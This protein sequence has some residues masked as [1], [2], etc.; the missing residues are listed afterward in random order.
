[1]RQQIGRT[2]KAYVS[3]HFKSSAA[4]AKDLAVS[5]QRLHSY[6]SGKSLPGADFF[7]MLAA[8]WKLNLL[9]T[10]PKTESKRSPGKPDGA[11]MDLF[12]SPIIVRNDQIEVVVK[13]KGAGLVAEIKISASVRVA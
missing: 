6:T 5:R 11:Q 12:S 4:A 9:D 10:R 3:A 7:E 1:M 2:V 13:R 8:Q